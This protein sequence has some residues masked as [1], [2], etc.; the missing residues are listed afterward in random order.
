M[1]GNGDAARAWLAK[2]ESDLA[3]AHVCINANVALDAACFHCQQA[4]EKFLK[5]WLVARETQFPF[6]HDLGKLVSLCA[7]SE[8]EFERLQPEA[9]MLTPFAIQIRYSAEFWPTKSDA[10]LALEAAKKVRRVVMERWP[11]RS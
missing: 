2:G 3:A 11:A 4:A 10:N 7:A 5:A 1:K 8:A 6:V 9:L